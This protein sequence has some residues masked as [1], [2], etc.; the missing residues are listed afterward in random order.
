MTTQITN[1]DDP[2]PHIVQPFIMSYNARLL[3]LTKDDLHSR[4]R[5]QHLQKASF[6]SRAVRRRKALPMTDTE[7]SDIA[8]AA[9]TGLSMIPKNG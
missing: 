1:H 9:M 8:K 2:M 4:Q 3:S 6:H 7:L 5:T